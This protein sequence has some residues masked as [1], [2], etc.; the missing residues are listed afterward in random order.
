MVDDFSSKPL[1]LVINLSNKVLTTIDTF[2][3][4]LNFPATFTVPVLQQSR[5]KAMKVTKMGK[6]PEPPEGN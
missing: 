2:V 1:R 3:A 6:T 4:I 5:Q